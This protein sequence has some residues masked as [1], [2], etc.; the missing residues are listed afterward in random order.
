MRHFGLFALV[1]VSSTLAAC[2]A[3]TDAESTSSN[4]SDIRGC[5]LDCPDPPP[6][7]DPTPTPAPH[8]APSP[9]RDG[10]VVKGSGPA[11]YLMQGGQRRYL[12]DM[13]TFDAMGLA[14]AQQTT[15]DDAA[16]NALSLGAALP[17]QD[18]ANGTIVRSATTSAVYYVNGLRAQ[19]VPAPAT[20]Q[21]LGLGGR[22]IVTI[23]DATLQTLPKDG[24]LP[25]AASTFTFSLDTINIHELRAHTSDTDVVYINASVDGVWMNPTVVRLGD[26]GKAVYTPHVTLD[27]IV[28]PSPDASVVIDYTVYN[29]GGVT[30]DTLQQA[31][32]SAKGYAPAPAAGPTWLRPGD[33]LFPATAPGADGGAGQD[34][35]GQDAW[36]TAFAR[37]GLNLLGTYLWGRLFASCDGSVAWA[38]VSM[39]GSKML[40]LVATS[41]PYSV[42]SNFPGIDS[43]TGC[44]GNSNYDISWSLTKR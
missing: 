33:W 10:V 44:G 4:A 30:N 18:I 2:A 31:A 14:T 32:L 25:S 21:S 37:N 13:M 11:L 15:L 20:L 39:K 17:H 29:G 22:P 42:T 26:L 27:N 36:W 5:G 28:V 40:D 43:A 19:N 41:N 24:D 3:S 23:T 8:P 16:L 34:R 38:Q 9:V 35:G 12:P 1:T 6:P 7:P